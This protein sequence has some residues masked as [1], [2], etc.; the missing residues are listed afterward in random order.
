MTQVKTPGRSRGSSGFVLPPQ[1]DYTCL[2]Y[3]TTDTVAHPDVCHHT[4][5]SGP[6]GECA[7]CREGTASIALYWTATDRVDAYDEACAEC[8]PRVI[9][10]ALADLMADAVV[11]VEI[12]R[13]ESA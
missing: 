3:T 11:L 5:D 2:D 4:V 1:E 6:A 9:R 13:G 7:W 10:E 8:A 12:P